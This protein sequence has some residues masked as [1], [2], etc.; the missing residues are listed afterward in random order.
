MMTL[1]K[2][3]ST[4]ADSP[5]ISVVMTAYN[6]EKSI[7]SAIQ[8]ILNQTFV[9]F[10][11]III[12]DGSTDRTG[13][14]I[15]SFDDKRIVF[16]DKKENKGIA[17]ASNHGIKIARGSYIARMDADD[18]SLPERFSLQMD[19]LRK[20]PDIDVLG[21]ALIRQTGEITE[22]FRSP[23]THS[24]CI[25]K[26]ARGVCCYHST[27]MLK[28][29][30]F[31]DTNYNEEYRAA[32]DY[33]LWVDL[34]QR[35][36]KFSNLPVPLLRYHIHGGNISVT[37]REQQQYNANLARKEFIRYYLN[38]NDEKHDK[39]ISWLSGCIDQE[40]SLKSLSDFYWE[41]YNKNLASGINLLM[42]G[43]IKKRIALLTHRL[44]FE[45]I[46]IRLLAYYLRYKLKNLYLKKR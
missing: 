34:A 43:G 27:V 7:K 12:N 22:V 28:K 19:F 18:E 14:I 9:D 29:E 10:E 23:L 4:V 13:D 3:Q 44:S 38:I 6:A 21:T 37:M 2:H 40:I 5:T 20:N 17:P 32:V 11:F 31:N 30:I 42:K 8:S 41:I 45:K 25:D 35:G 46:S 33:K 36:K 15:N 16:I 24:Q 39:E 26:L 1:T